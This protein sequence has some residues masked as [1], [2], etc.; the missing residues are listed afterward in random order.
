M[1]MELELMITFYYL[2][3]FYYCILVLFKLVKWLEHVHVFI[4]YEI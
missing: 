4:S 3:V 2:N 1:L